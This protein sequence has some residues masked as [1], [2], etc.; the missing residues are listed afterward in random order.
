MA[1]ICWEGER[2]KFSPTRSFRPVSR[3]FGAR[4]APARAAA[5]R[6][7]VQP[8]RCPIHGGCA[9]R[10]GTA[11]TSN[12]DD[13]TPSTPSPVKAAAPGREVTA[14][15]S[16]KP[17]SR[18]SA[19]TTCSVPSAER[20]GLERRES[21]R[22]MV[23]AEARTGANAGRWELSPIPGHS[24]GCPARRWMSRPKRAEVAG[25]VALR[26]RRPKA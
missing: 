24:H 18:V 25:V 1:P 21:R 20:T 9:N 14:S 10:A 7:F 3:R 23:F 13:S 16:C 12:T 26:C 4:D 5:G 17:A 6:T 15:L 19:P 8:G 22:S 2:W 11:G